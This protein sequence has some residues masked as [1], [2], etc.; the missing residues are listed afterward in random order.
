MTNNGNFNI[1]D[2]CT[3]TYRTSMEFNL[4]EKNVSKNREVSNVIQVNH[5]RSYNGRGLAL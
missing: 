2:A 5:L 4:L 1:N 3:T